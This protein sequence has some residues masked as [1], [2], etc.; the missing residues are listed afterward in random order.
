MVLQHPVL[1]NLSYIE[2]HRPTYPLTYN[3]FFTAP[4]FSTLLCTT[5]ALA[6]AL[7][8]LHKHPAHHISPPQPHPTKQSP[9]QRSKLT[10]RNNKPDRI[11][12]HEV[13]PEIERLWTIILFVR[14]EVFDQ[15]GG[16][17]EKV[18][19]ELTCGDKGLEGVTVGRG[20]GYQRG[21]EEGEGPPC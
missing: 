4:P 13:N 7:P 5:N 15:A 2:L 8:L 12:H 10:G 19:V 14:E 3:L 9:I 16:E 18:A 20:G 21:G 17:V 6:V 1:L 11:H